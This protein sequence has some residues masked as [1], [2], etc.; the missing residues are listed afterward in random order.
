MT[1]KDHECRKRSWRTAEFDYSMYFERNPN[2]M[3]C[4]LNVTKIAHMHTYI[5]NT[6]LFNIFMNVCSLQ[7][8]YNNDMH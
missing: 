7:I 8:C 4:S 1:Q 5:V 6:Q 2:F 3:P